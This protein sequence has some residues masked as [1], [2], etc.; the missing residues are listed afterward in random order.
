[1]ASAIAANVKAARIRTAEILALELNG[2]YARKPADALV[3]A[4][5]LFDLTVLV[6]TAICIDM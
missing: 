3:T 4:V 2:N 1:M 5:H 6:H